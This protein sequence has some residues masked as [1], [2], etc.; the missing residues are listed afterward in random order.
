MSVLRAKGV[1]L[2]TGNRKPEK[3]EW[4]ATEHT[5]RAISDLDVP[6]GELA[7]AHGERGSLTFSPRVP[8]QHLPFVFP[9]RATPISRLYSGRGG[10]I[11]PAKFDPHSC[12]E[13][14]VQ[15]SM[16]ARATR[17]PTVFSLPVKERDGLHGEDTDFDAHE[18]DTRLITGLVALGER[19]YV[20][21]PP[22]NW[23]T[24]EARNLLAFLTPHTG[25]L[26]P[27]ATM[28][29]KRRSLQS[30]F[31]PSD[32]SHARTPSKES[33]ASYSS[34][35][36][37]SATPTPSHSPPPADLLDD[38]P[39]ANLAL[40]RVSPSAP[41]ST[42]VMAAP[43]PR[44]P[45]RETHNFSTDTLIP[46][47]RSLAESP[48]PPPVPPKDDL[49]FTRPTTPR[50]SS[51]EARP[52]L[53]RYVNMRSYDSQWAAFGA[54]LPLEPWA[55]EPATPNITAPPSTPSLSSVFELQEPVNSISAPPTPSTSC[56]P[57]FTSSLDYS[58][59]P[60]YIS[61]PDYSS[62]DSRSNSDEE[63][64]E[65]TSSEEEELQIGESYAAAA[66]VYLP[67]N[68]GLPDFEE[69]A[70]SRRLSRVTQSPSRLQHS[71]SRMP[72]LAR[73]SSS[74]SGSSSG[75]PT[76]ASI[77]FG[78]D[79]YMAEEE[80]SPAPTDLPSYPWGGRDRDSFTDAGRDSFLE[81]SPRSFRES[82][83]SEGR[84]PF[85]ADAPDSFSEYANFLAA[86]RGSILLSNRDSYL[87]L[88]ATPHASF[89]S[90]TSQ[91]TLRPL[92]QFRMAL[93]RIADGDEPNN[94]T[95]SA[96]PSDAGEWG[97]AGGSGSGSAPMSSSAYAAAFASGSGA[98]RWRAGGQQG[99][100]G[101]G[102]AGGEP[103][104][105]PT[106]IFSSASE[107]ESSSSSS[108][109]SEDGDDVPLAQ[110]IPGALR[111]QRTIR[112]KVREEREERR[113][114]RAAQKAQQHP[115]P[116]IPSTSQTQSAS[117]SANHRAHP[118]RGQTMPVPAQDLTARLQHIQQAGFLHGP[119]P[120]RAKTV[121]TARSFTDAHQAHAQ[122]ERS[123]THVE[124]S[125]SQVRSRSVAP[126]GEGAPVQRSKSHVRGGDAPVQRSK[127]QVRGAPEPVSPTAEPVPMP[128]VSV[129]R[130]RSVRAAGSSE[131]DRGRSVRRAP[132]RQ[133]T[134]PMPPMPPVPAVP[135]AISAVTEQT[136]I[137]V[138]DRQRFH[139][140]EVGPATRA[141]DVI[142]VVAAEGVLDQWVGS[143][144]WMLFE[145]AQDF[146]MERPIRPFE[147]V[148]DVQAGWNK[149]KTVNT[150]VLKL[151]P[152]EIKLRPSSL[153]QAS[154]VHGAYVEW[155][156]R[157][158]KWTKR[159][160]RLKE[161]GL[162]MSK[163]DN[164]KD[165][166][167]LCQLSNFDVYT[168]TRLYKAPKPF[169]FA[170]KSTDNLSYFE[171]TADYLHVFSCQPY[172]GEKWVEKIMLA[173]LRPLPRAQCTLLDETRSSAA[174]AEKH[175]LPSKSAAPRQRRACERLRAWLAIAQDL[176]VAIVSLGSRNLIHLVLVYPL[177][178]FRRVRTVF[179]W[180]DRGSCVLLDSGS[181]S[182]RL[183]FIFALALP[184]YP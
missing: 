29:K 76:D 88:P 55:D 115:V 42:P 48:T 50:A 35:G 164:G 117:T 54:R 120:E 175:H 70:L 165:A 166:V 102:G 18:H 61:A 37:D 1:L 14:S 99:G 86:A 77:D 119:P 80:T 65:T 170:I 73:S 44:S 96:E 66:N 75:L 16:Y 179:S 64:E 57:D 104:R 181:L 176:I 87:T 157:R 39:F 116:A 78:W 60:D 92:S 33:V 105:R 173:R 146:G 74:S 82:F 31:I 118:T 59:H 10:G 101:A 140:V 56:M 83:L 171:D 174:R 85:L 89:C 2:A 132:E 177:W 12:P 124:R 134:V 26:L 90:S 160:L 145:V 153:P 100:G 138:G 112:R 95:S 172:D 103:P 69:P 68:L 93:A 21:N 125:K 162:W 27:P 58:S 156:S 81:G 122:V 154:P 169:V 22:R 7:V 144:G 137:F 130:G 41:P 15:P 19:V 128:R 3:S 30:L 34:T 150:L 84:D 11:D 133:A 94:S 5:S 47:L 131:L 46:T 106:N 184:P 51:S 161:H 109:S 110:R 23:R 63:T 67:S 148:A 71:L 72:S 107:T 40:P 135:A 43:T 4:A 13:G 79:G 24:T 38:D 36:S 180:F 129:E 52:A 149:D 143:G 111:A 168:V 142:D 9:A 114:E 182:W 108:S 91:D 155:E 32:A 159:Y 183:H 28:A 6:G 49:P 163:R 167:L 98:G 141:S 20:R 53:A 62:N 8:D 147:H 139:T 97:Q 178:I 158:G 126:R 121:R 127:S 151:T 113:R 45:L 152:L 25:N 136:R 123:R 17:V